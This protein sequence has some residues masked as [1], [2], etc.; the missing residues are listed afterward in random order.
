[1]QDVQRVV[2]WGNY[3]EKR[4]VD[5]TR[6]NLL[7]QRSSGATRA[8]PNLMDNH[9]KLMNMYEIDIDRYTVDTR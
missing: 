4:D 1:M 9:G 7:S 6:G 8:L 3:S 5:P 2:V